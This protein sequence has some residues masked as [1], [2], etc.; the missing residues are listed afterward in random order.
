MIIT[1]GKYAS[2]LNQFYRINLFNFYFDK[3]FEY[4][5]GNKDEFI[6]HIKGD[7]KITP[8][9]NTHVKIKAFNIL[10][11]NTLT[12]QFDIPKNQTYNAVIEINEDPHSVNFDILGNHTFNKSITFNKFPF[13]NDKLLHKS[14][15]KNETLNLKTINKEMSFHYITKNHPLNAIINADNNYYYQNKYLTDNNSVTAETINRDMNYKVSI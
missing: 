6:I 1:P 12:E 14:T 10:S 7:Y 5:L 4:I 13:N 15:G 11:Y 3:K 9:D 8:I 2:S